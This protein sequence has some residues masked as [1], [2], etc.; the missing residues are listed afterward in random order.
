MNNKTTTQCQYIRQPAFYKDFHCI[1]PECP[2]N[3]CHDWGN[4]FWQ[5]N[6]YEK[7][8]NADTSDTLGAF[9]K[10]SF[11]R[12]KENK[13][14]GYIINYNTAGKCPMLS[15]GGLCL[16]QRELGEEYLSETCRNYPRRFF[17]CGETLIQTCGISCVHLFNTVFEDSKA[18]KLELLHYNGETRTNVNDNF[19]ESQR[20]KNPAAGFNAEILDFFYDILSDTT[21]SIE[22]SLT[23]AFMAAGKIDE[24]VKKGKAG[25]LPSLLTALRPA[26][27]DPKQVKK[28]EGAGENISLKIRYITAYLSK[29]PTNAE[30]MKLIPDIVPEA[31]KWREGEEKFAALFPGNDFG[32]RNAALGIFLAQR[33]PFTDVKLSVSDNLLFM[34]AEMAVIKL[35]GILCALDHTEDEARQNFYIAASTADRAFSHNVKLVKPVSEFMREWGVNSPAYLLGILK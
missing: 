13:K 15:S 28:L 3:C 12:T 19:T 23:L 27:T 35:T 30:I 25:T 33:Q 10:F 31:E 4:I 1:G 29:F 11:K 5:I 17:L 34:A 21:R 14:D 22:T 6:E 24:A 9:I 32:M 2:T 8:K 16:V 20:M 7:L 26:L 18:M